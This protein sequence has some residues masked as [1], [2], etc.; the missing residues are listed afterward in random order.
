MVQ[1]LYRSADGD[2]LTR[3]VPM[4][5]APKIGHKIRRGGVE[6]RRVLS[7]GSV[8]VPKA[9]RRSAEI[10][11]WSLDPKDVMDPELHKHV[12]GWNEHGAPCFDSVE[13]A[14][15]FAGAT[16]DRVEKTGEGQFYDYGDGPGGV[17]TT[18]ANQRHDRVK[19]DK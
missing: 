19:F 6:Y 13:S 12:D 7:L 15:R 16:R 4:S 8:S 11:G 3:E 17:E 2:T 10:V 9:S 5:K 14:K 18:A 1:Y